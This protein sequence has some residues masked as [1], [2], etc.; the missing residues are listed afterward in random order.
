[1]LVKAFHEFKRTIFNLD[2][3]ISLFIEEIPKTI[4]EKLFAQPNTPDQILLEANGSALGSVR[5]SLSKCTFGN[6]K[7]Q[8]TWSLLGFLM[9]ECCQAPVSFG[10]VFYRVLIDSCR[11][12]YKLFHVCFLLEIF[13]FIYILRAWKPFN[14]ML[15]V[16]FIGIHRTLRFLIYD[17]IGERLS[18]RLITIKI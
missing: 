3:S 2:I 14:Q 18:E 16:L 10:S 15:H 1:M 8:A 7:I 9:P 11:S 17:R 13:C 4:P 5:E 6:A 12:L